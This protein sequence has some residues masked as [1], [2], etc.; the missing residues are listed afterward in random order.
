MSKQGQKKRA[1]PR[2]LANPELLL[3]TIKNDYYHAAYGWRLFLQSNGPFENPR[4]SLIEGVNKERLSVSF[5]F[6]QAIA[7]SDCILS[8]CRLTDRESTDRVNLAALQLLVVDNR[9]QLIKAA[10]EQFSNSPAEIRESM[11]DG[12][13]KATEEKIQTLLNALNELRSS[14]SLY[15]VRAHRDAV[16]AHSLVDK[17]PPPKTADVEDVLARIRSIIVDAYFVLKNTHYVL[18]MAEDELD[19]H[20]SNFWSA[21]ELGLKERARLRDAEIEEFCKKHGIAKPSDTPS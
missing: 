11:V 14:K 8:L 9:D 10:Q 20:F 17:P 15:G 16:I 18:E 4:K 5:N 7:I 2:I 6:I 1:P 19:R 21:F 13:G 3:D 12:A